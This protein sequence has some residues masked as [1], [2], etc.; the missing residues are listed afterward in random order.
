MP[1]KFI[2]WNPSTGRSN[3]ITIE[4]ANGIRLVS[5]S[6]LAPHEASD[7]KYVFM[8]FTGIC[9]REGKEIYEWDNVNVYEIDKVIA[10]GEMAYSKSQGCFYIRRGDDADMPLPKN[11]G[12]LLLV[13]GSKFE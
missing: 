2:A 5:Q 13:T 12:G 4:A 7:D 8:A 3:P 1:K 6:D 11:P 10:T 9:D